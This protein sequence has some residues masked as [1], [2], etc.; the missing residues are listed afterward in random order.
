MNGSDAMSSSAV[1]ASVPPSDRGA[2]ARTALS[3][4]RIPIYLCSRLANPRKVCYPCILR[5]TPK[6]DRDDDC[7]IVDSPG[8]ALRSI[9]CG[10]CAFP[11]MSITPDPAAQC[12]FAFAKFAGEISSSPAGTLFGC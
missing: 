4:G 12:I 11:E 1:R 5:E 7:N 8:R 9:W 10:S 6:L 3:V 2:R